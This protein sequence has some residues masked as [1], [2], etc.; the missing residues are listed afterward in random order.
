[1]M[2]FQAK[3]YEMTVFDNYYDHFI[4]PFNFFDYYPV[5]QLIKN[6]ILTEY[7]DLARLN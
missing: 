7:L 2:I 6:H 3:N 1:M 4:A 5:G